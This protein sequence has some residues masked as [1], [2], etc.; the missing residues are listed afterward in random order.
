MNLEI[1][2]LWNVGTSTIFINKIKQ[3]NKIQVLGN[4]LSTHQE[5]KA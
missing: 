4:K 2:Y 3:A 1:Y 5:Y